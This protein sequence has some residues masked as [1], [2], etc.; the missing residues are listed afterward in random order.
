MTDAERKGLANMPLATVAAGTPYGLIDG[1]ALAA[2]AGRILR[3]GK[4][5]ALP[6]KHSSRLFSDF[7]G[8]SAT[9]ASVDCHIEFGGHRARGFEMRLTG[10][11]SRE[12]AH[13]CG[14]MRSM[15]R[16]TRQASGDLLIAEGLGA[17]GPECATPEVGTCVDIVVWPA[18]SVRT[19]SRGTFAACRA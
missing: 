18:V 12:I 8:R 10:A 11:T 1:G 13:A 7:G 17:P 19:F 5:R 15:V 4:R 6:A 2:K 9:P 3:V 16:T 14:G